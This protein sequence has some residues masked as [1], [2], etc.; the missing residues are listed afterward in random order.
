MAYYPK[1]SGLNN[2]AAYQV[3]GKPYAT[4]SIDVPQLSEAPKEL[5]FP[6]VT[7]FVTI[8]NTKTGA[9]VPLRVGFSVSGITGSADPQPTPDGSD[10]YFVLDNG[11]SYTGEFRIS[12]LY[13]LADEKGTNAQAS[14]IAGLT[15][16]LPTDLQS[17]WSGSVGVG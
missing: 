9:N 1:S 12:R 13:L 6:Q 4:A 14:V 16:I 3:S 2:S 11:E 17:N 7:K 10:H 8:T 15:G 5:P